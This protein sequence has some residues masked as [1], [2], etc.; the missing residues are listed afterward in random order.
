MWNLWRNRIALIK[1][2]D[3]KIFLWIFYSLLEPL[4]HWQRHRQAQWKSEFFGGKKKW[5]KKSCE[6]FFLHLGLFR[7]SVS[8]NFFALN[9]CRCSSFLYRRQHQQHK[10]IS[11]ASLLE[12]RRYFHFTIHIVFFFGELVNL[13]IKRKHTKL[14]SPEWCSRVKIC[15]RKCICI[16]NTQNKKKKNEKNEYELNVVRHISLKIWTAKPVHSQYGHTRLQKRFEYVVVLWK[17]KSPTESKRER[18]ELSAI[19]SSRSRTVRREWSG[20]NEK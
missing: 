5:E 13:V 6:D 19:A 7:A 2:S 18:E 16:G 14:P 4:I 1:I 20:V 8:S 15:N 3:E 17:K 11:L 10:K 9:V 12:P